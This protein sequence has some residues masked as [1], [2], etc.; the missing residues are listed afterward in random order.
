M[1]DGSMPRQE[2]LSGGLNMRVWPCFL[3]VSA[4][5][6]CTSNTIDAGTND[7][8][9]AV[10]D[11]GVDAGP[12]IIASLIQ[13]IPTHLVSDGT[14]LFWI[15]DLVGPKG[16]IFGMPVVGGAI[17]TVL[18]GE[19]VANARGGGVDFLAVDDV[20]LYYP[21]SDGIYRA[22]KSG[23]GSSAL[24]NEAASDAGSG[25]HAAA[26]LGNNMYWLEN[27]TSE[28]VKSA[29][30]TGGP[31]S[32]IAGFETGGAYYSAIAVSA[33]TVFLSTGPFAVGRTT[34]GRVDSFPL[35]SGVPDG[36]RPANIPSIADYCGTLISDTDA[37]YC[38]SSS[39]SIFRVA[40]DGTATVLGTVLSVASVAQ[41][42]GTPS[43]VLA[44]D[45]RYLY[46]LDSLPV[47]TVM[48]VP[49]TGGTPSVIARDTSP[50]AVYW[51]DEGGNIMRIAK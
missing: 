32:T 13:L 18:P 30:L 12:T 43:A 7:A 26:V 33:S 5:A 23:E 38:L 44:L 40:S 34:G 47:G 14:S 15:C 3:F 25:L 36:G 46:W 10:S 48:R 27:G 2:V 41:Q 17:R 29:V 51:S 22:P 4:L 24:V 31:V 19:V 35:S 6:A 21:G 8:G 16:P 45:D 1:G 37:V 39:S 28:T 42:V 49:K 20:N 11:A 9:P 50:N